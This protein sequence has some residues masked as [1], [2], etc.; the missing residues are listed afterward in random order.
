MFER[1]ASLISNQIINYRCDVTEKWLVLI[2]IAPG[3]Q[4]VTHW[5]HRNN[6]FRTSRI[7][8]PQGITE[9]NF[10]NMCSFAWQ[11]PALVKGNMQL[12]SV[13]QQRS[14]ALEAHAAAFASI[15]V[16]WSTT[17]EELMVSNIIVFFS[18]VKKL[19][20]HVTFWFCCNCSASRKRSSLHPNHI[21]DE[22]NCGR[23][24][25]FQTARHWT[26]RSAR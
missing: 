15:E 24:A 13:D 22:S 18:R 23:A 21:C 12:F 10:L 19:G 2:G 9:S 8:L 26:G 1:T 14:Q 6:F 3:A 4:E 16:L 7:G 11:R 20:L 17:V 25:Y 5:P